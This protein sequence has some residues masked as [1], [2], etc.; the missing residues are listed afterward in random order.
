MYIFAPN[1]HVEMRVYYNKRFNYQKN[2]KV[3]FICSICCFG[4]F[5]CMF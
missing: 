2:E 4:W 5:Q 1:F 3:S